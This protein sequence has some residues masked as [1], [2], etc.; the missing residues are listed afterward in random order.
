MV[1]IVWR[2]LLLALSEEVSGVLLRCDN[3]QNGSILQRRI[4]PQMSIAQ[5]LRTLGLTQMLPDSRV[6]EL[7]GSWL[8]WHGQ[9]LQRDAGKGDGSLLTVGPL[10]IHPG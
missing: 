2:G 1:V 9:A 5:R 7:G 10:G 6:Q 3:A 4:R 8:A